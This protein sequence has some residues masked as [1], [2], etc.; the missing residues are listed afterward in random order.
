MAGF[1]DEKQ[2]KSNNHGTSSLASRL[3]ELNPY[4]P[5]NAGGRFS[6]KAD[7]ASSWSWV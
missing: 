2:L 5:K 3:R 4:R 7:T 6:R 1:N